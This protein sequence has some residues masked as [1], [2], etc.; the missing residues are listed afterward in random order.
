MLRL[1]KKGG[2]LIAL[3]LNKSVPFS[4]QARHWN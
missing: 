3:F 1:R 4:R 2:Y